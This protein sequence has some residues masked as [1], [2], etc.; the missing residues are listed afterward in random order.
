M[1]PAAP[2]PTT[3]EGLAYVGPRAFGCDMDYVA[4]HPKPL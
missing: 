3:D 1:V 4:L 2:V